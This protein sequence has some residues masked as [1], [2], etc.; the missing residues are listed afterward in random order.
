M[1]ENEL[2]DWEIKK[3]ENGKRKKVEIEEIFAEK[4]LDNYFGFKR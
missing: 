2:S 3:I 1:E 4:W